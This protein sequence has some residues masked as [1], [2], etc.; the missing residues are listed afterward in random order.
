[1]ETEKTMQQLKKIAF[2][3]PW[4]GWDIPGGAE[5]EC[6]GIAEHMHLSGVETEILTT[7]VEKFTA[8]WDVDFHKP[9]EYREHGMVIRRF[10]VDK[11]KDVAR[12]AFINNKLMNNDLPLSRVEEEDF[13]KNMVNSSDLYRYIAEHK[14]EY[15]LFIF[16]PYMFGT[17]YYGLQECYDQAVIIPCLHEEG[18]IHMDIFAEVFSRVKGM[19]FHAKPEEELARQVYDLEHVNAQTLGEGIY[20]DFTFDADRFREKFGIHHP[21]ILYAGRK[22]VGK[23]IHALL[24]MF[25]EYKYTHGNT[26]KMVLIGGGEV[27]I[28]SSVV[29]DVYDLGYVDLQDKYDAYAAAS[30]LCQPSKHESFSL[31]IMES[32][33]AGRPVLVHGGCDVTKH[34][35]SV[36]NGGFYFDNYFEFERQV[37]TLL[38]HPELADRMGE[39][40][41]KFV[42]ENFAWDRIVEKYTK[43][44]LECAG[45]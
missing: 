21:F 29:G 36:S 40:G 43:F 5:A 24:G 20:T 39:N 3:I 32:W 6:R 35:A 30:M 4:F 10:K 19:I 1:M 8:D 45:Q 9:G 41:R 22:D 11:R 42:L 18:Y 38:A 12:F 31:V 15:S 33:M 28:P 13:Q 27:E 17:T 44:F 16:I 34:F 14:R 2:V 26:L 7:C 23:N 25:E 37:D